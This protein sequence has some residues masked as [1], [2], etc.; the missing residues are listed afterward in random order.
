MT[1]ANLKSVCAA[2]LGQTVADLTVDTTD[3]FLIAANNVRKNAELRHNF[4]YTRMT[5]TLDIDGETGGALADAVLDDV[6]ASVAVSGT[7]SPDATGTYTQTSSTFAGFPVYFLAPYYLYYDGD[8]WIITNSATSTTNAWYLSGTSGVSPAGTYTAQGSF[9]GAPVVV[10][11]STSVFSGIKEIIALTRTT[12]NGVTWPI[13]FTREDIRI[14][15]DRYED[16][17]SDGYAFSQ[18]Y[19]SDAQLLTLGS[20]A[21]VVQRGQR[22]YVSPY[23][24]INTTPVNVNII[25]YGWLRDYTTSDLSDLNPSDFF[26]EHGF[27]YMQWAIVCELNHVFQRFVPRQEGV[28]SPPEQKAEAAWRDLLLWDTY[29]VDSNVTRSR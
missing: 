23:D 21:S 6:A 26:I 10:D 7:L 24:V 27:Q 9:T 17:L 13:D 25:G 16:E 3:L 11:S 12:V 18:R 5:A 14:E 4:E 22:L 2:I 8:D 19:P 20:T 28:L 1:L 15:R 29:M